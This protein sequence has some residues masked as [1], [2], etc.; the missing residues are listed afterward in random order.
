MC[1]PSLR[2]KE[3]CPKYLFKG[4]LLCLSVFLLSVFLDGGYMIG[5]G[6]FREDGNIK[7]VFLA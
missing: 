5:V 3:I 6:G 2:S 4:P 7:T 1:L